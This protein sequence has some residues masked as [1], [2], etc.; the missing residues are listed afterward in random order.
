MTIGAERP[1]YGTRQ[2]KFSPFSAHLSISPVSRE[3][4]SRF[5]PRISGQSPTATRRGA[6]AES[7]TP[8]ARAASAEREVT[9]CSMSDPLRLS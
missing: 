4:P 1:P 2:R 9:F 3:M 6:C 8:T 5:G 7:E